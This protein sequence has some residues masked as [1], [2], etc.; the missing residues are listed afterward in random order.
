MREYLIWSRSLEPAPGPTAPESMNLD[1]HTLRSHVRRRRQLPRRIY[2]GTE[3]PGGS[4][5]LD[6]SIDKGY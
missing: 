2:E 3:H 4:V 1:R 6:R 5:T